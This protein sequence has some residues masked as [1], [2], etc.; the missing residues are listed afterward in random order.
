MIWHVWD[1]ARRK[2]N[3]IPPWEALDK[4]VD[5][6]RL[7][8]Y[9]EKNLNPA[10]V[11]DFNDPKWDELKRRIISVIDKYSREPDTQK[12]ET[13][14]MA[15]LWPLME[16]K[17][18]CDSRPGQKRP[19][20]PYG[21]WRYDISNEF[22]DLHF[23]NAVQPKSPFDDMPAL[24]ADL[25]RLLKDAK[26]SLPQLTKVR[27]GTWLNNLPAFLSLF[28]PSWPLTKAG[29]VTGLGSGL[30]T[31]GQYIDRR[32]AFHLKNA[33]EFRANGR[34]PYFGFSCHC[35][36]AQAVEHLEKMLS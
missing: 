30:G 22:I 9:N 7:T 25:L 16:A 24:A 19:K 3:P 5:I 14:C 26:S 13:E 34:H 31:W 11:K 6:Y 23:G 8:V 20:S 4:Y 35:G 10:W 15:F 36:Y 17:I 21:C 1:L 12:I 29:G 28:P 32:G 33:Q 27:C 2:E 18:E